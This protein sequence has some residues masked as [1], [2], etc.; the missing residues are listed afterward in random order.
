MQEL[1][2]NLSHAM[3]TRH[4]VPTEEF[5]DLMGKI[6]SGL[7]GIGWELGPG[8]DDPDTDLLSLSVMYAPGVLDDAA[9]V[10]AFPLHG[11]GWMA[12][13]GIPPRDWEMYFRATLDGQR[14]EIEGSEWHWQ[15]ADGENGKASLVL[16]APASFGSFD[17]EALREFA[18]IIA[19]GE[20]GERNVLRHLASVDAVAMDQ[21]DAAW[22]PMTSLRRGFVE[23]FP[24]CAYAAWL[25]ASRP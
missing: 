14:H 6:V 4:Q 17:A 3:N 19:V 23:R 25:R 1:V 7:P 22:Q 21:P 15:M 20:L 13:L 10:A 16:A 18:H 12:D 9:F 24:T 8:L 11:E 2:N 5:I